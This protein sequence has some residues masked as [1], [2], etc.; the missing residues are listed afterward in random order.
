MRSDEM[1]APRV[2]RDSAESS[3]VLGQSTASFALLVSYIPLAH[4]IVVAATAVVRS[5]V[6]QSRPSH[7][8][9]AASSSIAAKRHRRRANSGSKNTTT[10][11]NRRRA[12]SPLQEK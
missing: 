10:L 1:F 12:P 7:T 11:I 3:F 4:P 6:R 2:I 9:L 5:T 8:H